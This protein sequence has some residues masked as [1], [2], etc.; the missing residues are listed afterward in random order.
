MAQIDTNALQGLG[1]ATAGTPHRDDK[2]AQQDFL[3]L[4]VTQLK[5]QDPLKPM[6]N[7]E[8]LSQ[9]AQ[10]STVTGIQDLQGSFTSFSE[11]MKSNQALQAASLVGRSVL[12]PVDGGIEHKAGALKGV[13][14]LPQSVSN[15]TLSVYNAA[16]QVVRRID[17]GQ[18][19]A[20][21]QS[22]EWDGRM[23]NGQAAAPG[24]YRIEATAA[25]NDKTTAL[26]AMAAAPVQSV[27]LGGANGV[28]LYVGGVGD[29]ALSKVRNIM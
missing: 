14:E 19:P 9:I 15:L 13:I 2:L 8:F 25:W 5:N 11:G 24:K 18:H 27:S 7:G 20:G 1:L 21:M 10:F 29:V 12:V 23:S 17:M 22:F 16:G 4:M 26:N 6:E 28:M 3:K